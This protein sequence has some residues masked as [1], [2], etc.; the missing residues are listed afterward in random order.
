M[1]WLPHLMRSALLALLICPV[2]AL[3]QTTSLATIQTAQ[4]APPEIK[5]LPPTGPSFQSGG[6][7]ATV[8]SIAA[9]PHNVSLSL[10][11][12]NK[13][14][15]NLLVSVIG[16]PIGT[17]GGNTFDVEAIG[18]I[19]Y[20]IFNP[21]RESLNKLDRSFEISGCLKDEKPQLALDSFTLIEAGNAVPMNLAFFMGQMVDPGQ[22]FSFAMNVAVFKESDLNASDNGGGALG[23]KS[24]SQTLPKSLRYISVGVT[25]IPLGQK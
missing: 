3:G 12:E 9:K 16:P 1:N 8:A 20:C 10:L 15:E 2:T 18:G 4:A 6:I 7:K 21:K 11:I 17:N 24:K 25:S 22:D 5:P 13:T 14:Q 19:S 23:A